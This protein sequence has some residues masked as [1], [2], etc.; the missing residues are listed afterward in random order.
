MVNENTKRVA[1]IAFGARLMTARVNEYG[2]GLETDGRQLLILSQY[3]EA[4]SFIDYSGIFRSLMRGLVI[5]KYHKLILNQKDFYY[6]DVLLQ[7]F[8]NRY[9]KE[10]APLLDSIF[11]V[12][13][14]AESVDFEKRKISVTLPS[15]YLLHNKEFLVSSNL[16]DDS[17]SEDLTTCPEIRVEYEAYKEIGDRAADLITP[18]LDRARSL[19]LERNQEELLR[20]KNTLLVLQDFLAFG[21]KSYYKRLYR[22]PSAYA[23]DII[24]QLLE[25]FDDAQ[26]DLLRSPLPEDIKQYIG[27]QIDTMIEFFQNQK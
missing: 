25:L 10:F 22:I 19:L 14:V 16:T 15:I 13:E 11:S 18:Q 2:I 7:I 9:P 8:K 24:E 3:N 21:N 17:I 1:N 6:K 26:S 23:S 27:S 4:G 5:R 12:F 20:V